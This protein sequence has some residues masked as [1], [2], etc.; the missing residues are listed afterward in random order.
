MDTLIPLGSDSNPRFIIGH[1]V[2]YDRIR[3]GSEYKVEP[4]GTRFLDTMSLH[5]A[6]SGMTSSQRMVKAGEKK[7]EAEVKPRWLRNASMNGLAD[8][9]A[10]YCKPD[11]PLQKDMRNSFVKLTLAELREDC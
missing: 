10:F 5:I 2:S 1:N 6:Y 8:C 9:H 4:S 3:I 11:T 7:L